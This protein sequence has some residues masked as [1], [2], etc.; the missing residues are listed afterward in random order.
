MCKW[1]SLMMG[2]VVENFR[3]VIRQVI[4]NYIAY[5]VLDIFWRYNKE[6]F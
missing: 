4:K 6:G 3:G 5:R 2:N 1:Q